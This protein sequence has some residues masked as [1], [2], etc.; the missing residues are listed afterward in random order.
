VL[1]EIVMMDNT[2]L[3]GLPASFGQDYD[4]HEYTMSPLG[5]E[6][7][8]EHLGS[9]DDTQ[10]PSAHTFSEDTP[11][12]VSS[13]ATG[14]YYTE[15]EWTRLIEKSTRSTLTECEAIKLFE[16]RCERDDPCGCKRIPH[17]N[18]ND[19]LATNA[20]VRKVNCGKLFQMLSSINQDSTASTRLPILQEITAVLNKNGCLF[21]LH[22][23]PR[24]DTGARF[25]EQKH[26]DGA[27][28][29]FAQKCI[30]RLESIESHIEH[31]MNAAEIDSIK[32]VIKKLKQKE[33]SLHV[34]CRS[35]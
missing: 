22:H 25:R 27:K 8:P 33:V 1:V 3:Q 21:N 12:A 26:P 19:H 10:D 34:L 30:P 29:W 32:T 23:W 16:L 4:S 24:I 7:T 17:N 11:D 9:M 5:Q 18:M 31:G 14:C 20:H 35:I 15:D 28:L 2:G 6:Y 13:V